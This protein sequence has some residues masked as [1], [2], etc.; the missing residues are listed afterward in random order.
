[1]SRF[2]GLGQR[3]R[4]G[5]D[6]TLT[7]RRSL[8]RHRARRRRCVE[9][10]DRAHR[11]RREGSSRSPSYVPGSFIPTTEGG[12]A[13][14]QDLLLQGGE[15]GVFGFVSLRS[16]TR[17]VFVVYEVQVLAP[18]RRR[19]SSRSATRSPKARAPPSTRTA[20]GRIFLSSRL[21]ALSRRDGGGGV[22]RRHR[23]GPLRVFGRRRPSRADPPRRAAHASERSLGRSS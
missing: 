16:T 19:R 4:R 10:S 13:T 11:E 8:E 5:N 14:D 22:Q 20:I 7:F 17:Q 23:V 12:R 6:R 3:H 21:P 2:G 9:R 1:M 15:P 18:G